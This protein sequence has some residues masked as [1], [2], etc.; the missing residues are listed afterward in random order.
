MERER[1]RTP[2]YIFIASAELFEEHSEVRVASRV[3]E[4]SL[5]GCYLD[6]MNPFPPGTIILLKI[7]AGDLTFQSKA[8][9]IYATQNVGAGVAFLDVE[10]KY[11]YVIKRW[12]EEAAKH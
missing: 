12:M 9:V 8:R 1:R 10:P 6:M 5:H 4:L 2:R 7:F 11:E 3:S